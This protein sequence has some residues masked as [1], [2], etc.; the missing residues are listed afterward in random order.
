MPFELLT[1]NK[2]KQFS[3]I[4][5]KKFRQSSGTFLIEGLHLFE[6]FLRSQFEAEWIVID[7]AF[8]E[9]HPEIVRTLQKKFSTITYR[10][11]QR[12]C[13]KL[14]DTQH[15]QGILAA[16]RQPASPQKIFGDSDTMIIA[17]DRI[18][19]PGNLGTIIR[20]ADWFGVRKIITS[21]SCVEIYNPKVVRATMGSI[22]R[23]SFYQ[24]LELKSSINHARDARYTVCAADMKGADLSK[25]LPLS[26]TLLLVGS[27]AHGIDKNLL[28]LCDKKVSIP[29]FGNGDSL[30]AAV[31]CG[32]ILHEL[33]VKQK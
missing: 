27:E 18:S 20:C 25:L 15:P 5:D 23:I 3:L 30:N 2:L 10:V 13:L 28:D 8:E 33:R 14:S 32:I 11:S 21:P 22:F 6:E 24:D 31:A 16:I 29:K 4:L 1:K 7:T 19:D 17:L 26:N 9:A 12:D